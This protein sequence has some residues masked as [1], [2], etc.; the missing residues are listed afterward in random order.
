MAT[1]I[2]KLTEA[3]V[4]LDGVTYGGIATEVT[5]PELK[6]ITKEHAPTCAKG[7]FNLPVGIELTPFMMKGD[8]EPAF[9]AAASDLYHLHMIQ[10][11][12]NLTTHDE[13]AGRSMEQTVVA[14]MRCYPTG[15]KFNAIKNAE[16]CEVEYGFNPTALK[17]ELDGVPIIDVALGTNKHDVLGKNQNAAANKNLGR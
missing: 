4:V 8:F 1:V 10:V 17:L 9:I 12:C 14:H 7:K 6:A 11:R 16:P 5:I 3:V 2:R 15:P 13:A